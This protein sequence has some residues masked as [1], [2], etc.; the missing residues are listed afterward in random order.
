MWLFAVCIILSHCKEASKM[1]IRKRD[2]YSTGRVTARPGVP[3]Q[4]KPIQAGVVQPLGLD[5]TKDG[6]LYLPKG[7]DR[8]KPAALALMLHGSGGNPEQ[9]MWLLQRY[10]DDHNIILIS[11]ASRKYTWD[12]I[13]TDTF[14]PDTI[15]I[16]QSLAF[17]FD[18][19]NIDPGK[20][21]IGGFSDGASYALCMGLTNGDVFTHIIAFSP[22]FGFTREKHGA[23]AVFISHGVHDG[24]LPIDPCGRLV[25]RDLKK[26][27]LEVKYLEFD[28]EHEIPAN[29]SQAAVEW[30]L[31]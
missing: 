20:V 18:H 27:G 28:G 31:K 6:L 7:Y 14:G 9:G 15:F 22:G 30:F 5:S 17:V 16:D 23:P 25:H 12:V 26:E 29:I 24:I 2:A 4:D 19:F 8:S 1:Q 3:T 21:A 10:A 11:P 13:V